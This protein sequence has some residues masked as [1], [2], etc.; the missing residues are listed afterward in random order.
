M[1]STIGAASSFLCL[2]K[3]LTMALC[4]G[5]FTPPSKINRKPGIM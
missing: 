5:P 2:A 3:T 1:V 4:K